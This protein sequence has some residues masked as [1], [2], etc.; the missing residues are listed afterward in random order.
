MRRAKSKNKAAQ[1]GG[2]ITKMQYPVLGRFDSGR[3]DVVVSTLR[4]CEGVSMAGGVNGN[5]S[6]Y[7][8]RA[9]SIYDPNLTGG[10]HQPMGRDLLSGLYNHY[11]VLSSTC[12]VTVLPADNTNAAVPVIFGVMLNED[13]TTGNT[14]AQNIIEQGRHVVYKLLSPNALL[15]GRSEG[16]SL[17]PLT[18]DC[19]KYFGCPNPLDEKNTVGAAVGTNPTEDASFICFLQPVTGNT[20]VGTFVFFVELEYTVA[21]S[22][23]TELT[24]N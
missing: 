11:T 12:K 15:N 24:A 1:L 16:V 17:G 6:T 19:A 4:Y 21:F 5:I 20:Q 18:F 3:P 7:V 10:G 23:P 14:Y 13:S 22:E 8:F 9:N 2:L